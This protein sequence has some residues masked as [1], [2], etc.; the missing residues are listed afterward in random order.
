MKQL[1][2]PK[3]YVNVI[4]PQVGQPPRILVDKEV[5]TFILKNNIKVT[6]KGSEYQS[7]LILTATYPD[8]KELRLWRLAFQIMAP[9]V[10]PHVL[11]VG[12]TSPYDCRVNSLAI[13]E[14]K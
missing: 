11:G 7:T 1:K 3:F 14:Q 5:R 4:S 6:A 2:G 13:V 12:V 9:E 10:E 8:G